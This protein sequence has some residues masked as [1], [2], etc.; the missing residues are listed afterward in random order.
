MWKCDACANV[1]IPQQKIRHL[2][3]SYRQSKSDIPKSAIRNDTFPLCA[4]FILFLMLSTLTA[5]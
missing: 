3:I 4:G 1:K 2:S 5:L